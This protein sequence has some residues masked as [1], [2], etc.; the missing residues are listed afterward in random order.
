MEFGKAN[1]EVIVLLHGGGLSWWN[2]LEAAEGLQDNYHVILPI[3]DGHSESDKDFTGIENNAAEIIEYIDRM[4]NGSVLLIGGLSLGGQVLVE[5][6]SQRGNICKFAIIESALV[7]PMKLTHHLIQPAY[8]VCYPLIKKKW[9]AKLQFQALH[10]KDIHFERY[11]RDSANISKYNLMAFMMA[12]SN[13]QLKNTLKRC[14]AKVLVCV[15]GRESSIM[16]KSA[17]KLA[18]CL[19]TA[20]LEVMPRFYHGDFNINHAEQYTKRVLQL[21]N[22]EI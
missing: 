13:Y 20:K 16:K 10:I 11:Y 17:Q 5:M 15:G 12:N 4:H 18:D 21:V 7:I 6:L 2:Y 9:F 22:S 3:L 14:K 19:P 8:S 1:N